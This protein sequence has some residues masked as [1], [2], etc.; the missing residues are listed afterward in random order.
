MILLTGAQLIC[1]FF[2]GFSSCN[3]QWMWWGE[4]EFVQISILV[5]LHLTPITRAWSFRH[6]PYGKWDTALMLYFFVRQLR[7]IP[8]T[9]YQI[10]TQVIRY[11]ADETGIRSSTISM[12]LNLWG[13]KNRKK[14][15]FGS[16]QLENKL[17]NRPDVRKQEIQLGV[18]KL[19]S[20]TT[21]YWNHR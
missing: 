14:K 18:I 1:R 17:I 5:R 2:S 15:D 20:I 7:R 11:R 12:F 3:G 21:F 9:G 19:L 13:D 6:R 16:S 10:S 4:G 8:V